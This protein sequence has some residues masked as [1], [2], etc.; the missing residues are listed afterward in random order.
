MKVLDSIKKNTI[1]V[2]IMTI[3][4]LYVV[5]KD[6]FQDIV[7]AFQNI[8]IWWILGAVFFFFLSV[9]IKGI[10]NYVV[11]SKQKVSVLE[12]IKH[13]IIIQFFNGVTPFATGGQPMEI[14]MLTEHGVPLVQATNLTIQNFIYYQI[15]LVLCGILAVTY[16]GIFSIFP[17]I[18]VLD[19]LVLIGFIINVMV[20]ILLIMVSCYKKVTL[21]ICSFCKWL[22]KRFHWQTTDEELEQKFRDYYDEFQKIRYK[23]KVILF[24]IFLNMLS[25]ICLYIVPLFVL[26]SVSDNYSLSV[27]HTLTASAYVYIM[28]AFIPIPG[29]SGGIEY[30]FTQFYGNFI[31]VDIITAVLLLWRF[32]TYY[33]GVIVGAMVFNFEKKV[34]K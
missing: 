27:I 20:A 2:L 18:K 1:L 22:A 10:A 26:Y 29:S 16:N 32:I 8:H 11:V 33:V 7:N 25:L 14:Y 34:K 23:K 6:D 24:T 9:V 15:A 3:I 5:L 17:K 12:I 30:G 21:K 19:H 4:V 28:G 13:N 31:G